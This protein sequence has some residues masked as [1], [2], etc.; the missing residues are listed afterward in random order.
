MAI[1]YAKAMGLQVIAVDVDDQKLA[2]AHDMGVALTINSR[3]ADPVSAV[4]KAVG[5]AHGVL[6]TAPSWKPF[7]RR[8]A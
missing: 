1:Q 5:G 7:I 8:S 4:E 3:T 2:M 6:V